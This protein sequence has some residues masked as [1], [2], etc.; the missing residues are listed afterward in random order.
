EFRAADTIID[1]S[2]DKGIV[3]FVANSQNDDNG[4]GISEFVRVLLKMT[5]LI[6][7]DHQNDFVQSCKDIVE[8]HIIKLARRPMHFGN[9]G[10]LSPKLLPGLQPFIPV[11]LSIFK[12]TTVS[13]DI[14][15]SSIT[16][17]DIEKLYKEC[18]LEA[19]NVTL[20]DTSAVA[21]QVADS[22]H[23]LMLPQFLCLVVA[24]C[25]MRYPNPLEDLSERLRRFLTVTMK[26][27]P[28]KDN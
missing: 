19:C 26:L 15:S 4:I 10:Y 24:L 13:E 7:N 20:E 11:L 12:S 2:K 1:T 22:N 27:S 8:N 28:I 5:A 17:D 6:S 3:R 18:G 25:A 21:A 16:V 23:I 14:I 9:P